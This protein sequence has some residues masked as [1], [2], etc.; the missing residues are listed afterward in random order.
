MRK[1]T[2]TMIRKR[3]ENGAIKITD[4]GSVTENKKGGCVVCSI[5]DSWFYAFGQEGETCTPEEYKKNVPQKV[6][7]EEI[8]SVLVGAS[9]FETEVPDEYE[10]YYYYLKEHGC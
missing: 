6:I 2:I 4:E 3:L 10:Y 8:H 5:G 7:A 9:G 1:I